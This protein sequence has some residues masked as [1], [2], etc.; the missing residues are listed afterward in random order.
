MPTGPPGS[1]QD[2]D[3]AD[4]FFVAGSNM[5]DCHPILFLRMK[6]RMK[7]AGAKLIVID[8]RRTATA[9]A[10]DLF[11]QI[12]PG[13]DI[14][15]FNG[16]LHLLVAEDRV[17]HDFIAEFTEGWDDMP[18]FL[19]DYAPARVAETT[20]IAE[21]DLRKAAQWIGE[22]GEWMSC[23]TMGLSQSISG[24]Y[25]TN[26]LCNLHLATG[27]ICRP[28]SGPFSLTGQ[29]NA[30]GGREV[31][32]LSY[33][34][35]GQRSVTDAD[36]RRFVEDKWDLAP[37]TIRAE[38]GL[39]AASMYKA[40]QTGDIKA[41]WIICTNPVATTPNRANAIA[42]LKAAELVITQD[43]YQDTET[44]IYA[45]IQ[46]PGALWAEATG[47]MVNSERNL[48]L[49]DKAVEPPGDAMP[50]WQIIAKVA[51]AMATR[52]LSHTNPPPRCSTRSNNSGTRRPA[53]T[54]AA[55]RTRGCARRR[56][57]GPARPTRRRTA[58]RSAT[59]TTASVRRSAS[60]RTVRGR[61]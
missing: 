60:A 47:V 11:L 51:C 8:P 10:A 4:L 50:D 18:A 49:M 48:T 29:P 25:N 6:D 5:A 44:N 17:D 12:R 37:G 30:M 61:S 36:D 33:G 32:Y 54:S 16:L 28:G 26:A 55:R 46:L 3:K 1:Y 53:T 39:D 24:T 40:M 9:E 38:A 27:A 23:W 58:T 42:G 13:T 2:F 31:G 59:S 19:E 41:L 22:A 57:N 56:C 35:P 45:D 15:L 7:R 14:A 34:L 43:A 21:A 52:R 20:G